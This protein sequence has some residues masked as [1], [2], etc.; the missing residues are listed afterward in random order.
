MKSGLVVGAAYYSSTLGVW[1]GSDK[2]EVVFKDAY[3]LS[4]KYV[5]DIP[6]E[7]YF[8]LYVW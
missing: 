6:V 4:S 7:V 1:Q 3:K 5:S 8:F 2:S